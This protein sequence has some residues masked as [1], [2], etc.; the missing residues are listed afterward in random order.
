[1]ALL[2][3]KNISSIQVVKYGKIEIIEET[4]IEKDGKQIASSKHGHLLHPGDD[5]SN[6][7]PQVVAV[8]T[9]IW[10]TEVVEA[11]QAHLQKIN[12]DNI[13]QD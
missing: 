3:K 7:D 10:T 2:E 8:A 13:T 6:E 5:L 4:I 12:S 1:M 9:A 11:W